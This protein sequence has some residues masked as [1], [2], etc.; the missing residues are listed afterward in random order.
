[1]VVVE[2]RASGVKDGNLQFPRIVEIRQ[3]K[4]LEEIDTASGVFKHEDKL[5]ERHSDGSED[6]RITE[7]SKKRR[8]ELLIHEN[9]KLVKHG[10]DSTVLSSGLKGKKVCVL[11]GDNKTSPQQFQELLISLGAEPVAN[12][13]RTTDFLIATNPKHVR[14][15]GA[16]KQ[17]SMHIVHGD[18]LL[19]CKEAGK[20]LPWK[21]DDLIHRSNNAKFDLFQTNDGEELIQGGSMVVASDK[22]PQNIEKESQQIQEEI[23]ESSSKK[24]LGTKEITEENLCEDDEE[25]TSIP[26]DIDFIDE[27]QIAT[28]GNLFE[29]FVFFIHESIPKN[30]AKECQK[31]IEGHSGIVSTKLDISVTHVVVDNITN[32]QMEE[33]FNWNESKDW[34][35]CFVSMDWIKEAID[36]DDRYLTTINLHQM[37]V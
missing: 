27:I 25:E 31:Q 35:G 37:V 17:N 19:K 4:N 12:P 6:E 34:I 26:N 33:L 21:S 14:V 36:E 2:V 24:P 7:P 15:A 28:H 23:I 29:G 11:Q 32:N 18:W 13:S 3:D 22:N 8:R 30:K 16:I 1:M 9:Y 5:R 10:I 20:L